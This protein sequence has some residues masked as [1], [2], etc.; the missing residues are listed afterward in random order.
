MHVIQAHSLA[1]SALKICGGERQLL[2][3]S[4]DKSIKLWSLDDGSLLH[5]LG[6]MKSQVTCISLNPV[7]DS[8]CLVTSFDGTLKIFHN[9]SETPK[10]VTCNG[11]HKHNW[12]LA[13]C[14]SR[15]GK[16]IFIGRRNETVDQ[17]DVETGTVNS[18]IKLLPGSG[19]VSALLMFP[20]NRHLLICS[21]DTMR[22]WDLEFSQSGDIKNR[23]GTDQVAFT[24]IPGH[25]SAMISSVIISVSGGSLITASGS[26]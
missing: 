11:I 25:S 18:T 19:W 24:T 15:C 26:R 3:G 22:L 17:V 6:S 1:V 4:W 5:D 20:N 8:S 16:K 21:Y 13:A 10:I 2:S 12:S 9:F 23:D 7:S 14:W